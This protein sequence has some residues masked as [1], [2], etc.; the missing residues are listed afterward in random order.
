MDRC[1]PVEHR[2]I[3]TSADRPP[4]ARRRRGSRSVG[5]RHVP[6]QSWP[7]IH[8]RMTGVAAMRSSSGGLTW[9]NGIRAQT[10]QSSPTL[11]KWFEIES[12]V[13]DV[14]L[15]DS[16]MLVARVGTRSA[17]GRSRRSAGTMTSTTKR[18]LARGELPR[19][20]NKRPGLLRN[21]VMI[22]LKTRWRSAERPIEARRRLSPMDAESGRHQAS[23][24][25]SQPGVRQLDAVDLDA[26]R[27]E[28]QGYPASA[29]G[30]FENPSPRANWASFATTGSTA[31][32]ANIGS[33]SS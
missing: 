11:L 32:A 21:D 1:T 5:E 26:A 23:L 30:Q 19:S 25:A 16:P 24:A 6:V 17:A 4:S 8:G 7:A 13:G 10:G 33:S 20:R 2:R 29:D 3:V 12:L 28:W 31:S 27:G 14:V 15:V 22:V 18:H 9:L